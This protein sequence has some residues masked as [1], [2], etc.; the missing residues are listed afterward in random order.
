[1]QTDGGQPGGADVLPEPVGEPLGMDR[2]AV[3]MGE[4]QPGIL[5]GWANCCAIG[6]LARLVLAQGGHR[7]RVESNRPPAP[8][9]LRLRDVNGVVGN[10]A[11]LADSDAG[12]VQVDVDP[13]Q[14]E[15]LATAHAG[16]GSQKPGGVLAITL[17]MGQEGAEL[18]GLQTWSSAGLTF[19]GSAASAT[20]RTT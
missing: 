14:P 9:C 5:V 10:H 2:R 19:G 13:T 16:G 3:W 8:G 15:Q 4:D 6:R 20:L 11:R 7:H 17:N 18:V 12:G 1:M